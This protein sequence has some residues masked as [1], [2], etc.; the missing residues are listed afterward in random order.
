M[1]DSHCHLD[2]LELPAHEGALDATLAAAR[3]DGVAGFLCINVD[4]D[5]AARMQAAVGRH[6]D[7]WFA[8]GQHPEGVDGPVD[9]AA[10]EALLEL[11]RVVAVGESGLDYYHARD[12]DADAEAQR[13]AWQR[14]SFATHLR[15]AGAAR[16]PTVVHSRNATA[17]TCAL[18]DAHASRDCAGV[19]HCF[20]EDLDAGMAYI[21]LGFYLSISGIVTFRN[22]E[23]LRDTVRSLPLD[24]LLIETDSPWLA[25]VPHRGKSNEPRHVVRVAECIAE[26]KDCSVETIDRAT[27]ENFFRLFDRAA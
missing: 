1:I 17:D 4:L 9:P 8:M 5:G 26:L 3:C 24:R 2:R 6:D 11:P 27:T 7:V 12:A 16:L 18:I 15:C 21:E 23:A 22:A 25:P 19:I 14:E 13:F 10:L 20:T